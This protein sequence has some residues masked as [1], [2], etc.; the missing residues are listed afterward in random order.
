MSTKKPTTIDEYIAD[1]PKEIQELL[2]AVRRTIR[3][4]APDAIETISYGIPAFKLNSNSVW[5]AAY[6]KHIGM[7]PM[8]GMEKYEE[9]IEKYRGKGTKGTMQFPYN[10]PLPLEFISKLVKFKFYK[11][12]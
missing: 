6:K 2:E 9:E 4:A 11:T 12:F 8:Y 5:F 7:Y 10:K 3:D 1:F